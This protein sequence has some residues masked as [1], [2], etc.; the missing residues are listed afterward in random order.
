[1]K[2][3]FACL[4]ALSIFLLFTGCNSIASSDPG[5]SLPEDAPSGTGSMV[6]E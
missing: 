4:M 2:R 3:F 1:M 5:G 6:T